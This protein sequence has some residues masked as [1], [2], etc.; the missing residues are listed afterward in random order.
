[1]FDLLFSV[2]QILAYKGVLTYSPALIETLKSGVELPHGH[3][4][5]VEI[6][7]VSIHAVDLISS[8]VRR[9][10]ARCPSETASVMKEAEPVVGKD[11]VVVKEKETKSEEEEMFPINSVLVD[12]FLWD[13]RRKTASHIDAA[14]IPFHKT[15]CIFY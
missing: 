3:E 6:R 12:F 13:L 10:M 5:E 8:E 14:G 7:G 15:R 1:M 9:L 4:M 11:V 2:P